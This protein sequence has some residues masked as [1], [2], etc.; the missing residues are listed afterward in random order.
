MNNKVGR[1]DKQ[2]PAQA[3]S[4]RDDE[5]QF[6]DEYAALLMARGMPY[7]SGCVYGLL[8]LWQRP[9]TVDE[10]AAALGISRVG[11]WSAARKLET[12]GHV[13]R[14]GITGS[15]KA[16]YSPSDQVGAPL[17]GQIRLLADVAQ[18]LRRCAEETAQGGAV[19][20]LHKRAAYYEAIQNALETV[21]Q[22]LNATYGTNKD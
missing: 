13:Q 10:I 3:L 1:L 7:S 16:L 19:A 2:P 15:K 21:I 18:L 22:E 4:L 9:S 17:L 11:A 20:Q 14:H 5:W 6:I 8:L 12:H